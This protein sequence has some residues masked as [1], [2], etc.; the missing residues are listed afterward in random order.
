MGDASHLLSLRELPLGV[1]L[2]WHIVDCKGRLLARQ[3]AVIRSQQQLSSLIKYQPLFY[4][5]RFNEFSQFVDVLNPFV[6]LEHVA[7]NLDRIFRSQNDPSLKKRRAVTQLL[8]RLASCV[9]N[10]CQF[11]LDALIGS[12]HHYRAPNY[13]VAHSLHCAVLAYA[14]GQQVKLSDAQM[15]SLV[16]AALSANISIYELQNKLFEQKEQLS[17]AQKKNIR[18]HPMQSAVMLKHHGIADEQWLEI[19]LSH[20]ENIDGSGYPRKRRGEEIDLPA[21]I[22][23]LVDRYH[24]MI[25]SRRHRPGL[26]PAQALKRLVALD[27]EVDKKLMAHFV[28][29]V[30]I[31]PPGSCVKLA[32][33]DTA[34]ITRANRENSAP[35]QYV[36]VWDKN[37]VMYEQHIVCDSVTHPEQQIK[38]VC[39][40]PVKQLRSLPRLWGYAG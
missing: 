30:G 13:A 39:A 23:S 22:L 21:R 35:P 14:L 1:P 36:A 31:F 32:N 2:S 40:L 6:K 11:D 34:M 8:P 27:N 19:V 17:P 28:R 10:L 38:T 20:H 7:A 24:A 15:V 33:G 25:S 18:Q 16:G 37:D 12:A 4:E 29:A 3:G 9:I 5:D 26:L